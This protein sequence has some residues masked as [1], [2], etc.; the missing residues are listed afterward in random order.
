MMTTSGCAESRSL[1]HSLRTPLRLLASEPSDDDE[2]VAAAPLFQTP[3]FRSHTHP[4]PQAESNPCLD[5]AKP[6]PSPS[7]TAK[8]EPAKYPLH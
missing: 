3:A 8:M 2:A 1:T 6:G 7:I 5:A 4:P